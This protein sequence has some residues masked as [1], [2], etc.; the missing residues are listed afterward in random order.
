MAYAKASQWCKE[1]G[2]LAYFETSAKTATSVKEMFEEIAKR[3]V[4]TQKG[5]LYDFYGSETTSHNNRE[6]GGVSKVNVVKRLTP[7]DPVKRE[8]CC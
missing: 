6:I 8:G 2:G 7:T 4:E 3:A 5:K 1:N